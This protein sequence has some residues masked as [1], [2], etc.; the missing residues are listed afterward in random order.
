MRSFRRHATHTTAAT[1]FR[2][3]SAKLG[4]INLFSA[5]FRSFWI[6]TN[7]TTWKSTLRATSSWPYGSGAMLSKNLTGH[8]NFQF[9]FSHP[10]WTLT[11]TV[12]T[13][14]ESTI[15]S[16]LK[17]RY[18]IMIGRKGVW[19]KRH[20]RRDPE[21]R[22]DAYAAAAEPCGIRCQTAPARACQRSNF[23]AAASDLLPL[24]A[25]PRNVLISEH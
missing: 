5:L 6:S 12:N 17:Y 9:P 15:S 19:R 10:I 16:K 24:R 11:K 13:F 14:L 2:F 18:L 8:W 25:C 21:R 20:F 22:L 7:Q 3:L 1:E 23:G 4:R